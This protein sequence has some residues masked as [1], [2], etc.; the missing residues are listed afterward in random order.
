MDKVDARKLSR[1][2][3]K[4]LRGQAMRMRQELAM[5]WREIARIMG[6]NTTVFGWAQRYTA[7]GE[8]GLVSRK[9]GRAY[10]SGRTLTLP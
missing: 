8:A 4:V 6:L 1:D 3:L 7:Q 2:T 9:P 5:P 10:L